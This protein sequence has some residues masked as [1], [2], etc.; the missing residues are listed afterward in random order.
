MPAP[1]QVPDEVFHTDV[2]RTRNIRMICEFFIKLNVL[3]L[4][5][6][7]YLSYLFGI[8]MSLYYYFMI[9]IIYY[10]Y[11]IKKEVSKFI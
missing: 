8:K 6:R 1:E 2:Y 4:I 7:F 9:V 3:F 11:V 5:L 10:L